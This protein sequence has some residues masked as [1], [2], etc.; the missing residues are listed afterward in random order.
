MRLQRIWHRIAGLALS[1]RVANLLMNAA[2]DRVCQNNDKGDHIARRRHQRIQ[3]SQGQLH[4]LGLRDVRFITGVT[5]DGQSRA[6]T[7]GSS[8]FFGNRPQADILSLPS[9]AGKQFIVINDIRLNGGWQR[10]GG[11]KADAG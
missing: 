8:K 9:L 3:G 4:L 1:N 6:H 10:Q 7:D 11:A 5:E 2:A